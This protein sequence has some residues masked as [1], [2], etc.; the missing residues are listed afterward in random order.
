M[1][2]T[3]TYVPNPSLLP[4]REGRR[5]RETGRETAKARTTENEL[6]ALWRRL[7]GRDRDIVGRA[8]AIVANYSEL[9]AKTNK[10]EMA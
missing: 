2:A 10:R 4:N 5:A 3:I 8:A 7:E 6:V 9:I 1:N